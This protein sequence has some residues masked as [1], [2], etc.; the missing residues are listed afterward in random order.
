MAYSIKF[1]LLMLMVQPIYDD[2]LFYD[3]PRLS[4]QDLPSDLYT[5]IDNSNKTFAIQGKAS[6]RLNDAETIKLGF[7]TNIDVAT[8]YTLSIAQLQGNFLNDNA[9]YLKDNMT[10]KVHTLRK[11]IILLPQKLVSLTTALW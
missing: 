4:I 6:Y 11:V 10:G 8:L 7:S 5:T 3:A 2:G 1:W 9:I